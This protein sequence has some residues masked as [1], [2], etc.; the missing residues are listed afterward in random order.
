MVYI[1]TKNT[2][3]IK[4]NNI[5][6]LFESTEKLVPLFLQIVEEHGYFVSVLEYHFVSRE[7]LLELNKKHLNHDFDTDIITFDYTKDNRLSAECFV[8]FWAVNDSAIKFKSSLKNE[9]LR[10]LIHGLLH[11]IGYND[12]TKK[13][14]AIMRAKETEYIKLFHVKH[15][16]HV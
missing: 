2:V 14:Q 4:F 7:A 13:E 10:V 1:C 8:S 6:N 12:K 5:P 16:N 9:L 3:I 11:C 15:S